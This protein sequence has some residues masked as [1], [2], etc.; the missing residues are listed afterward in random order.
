MKRKVGAV[1]GLGRGISLVEEMPD[2]KNGE[3]E[4]EV[5]A[6]LISPGSELGSC[7]S[8]RKNP[9]HSISPRPIGYANA[10]IVTKIGSNVNDFEIGQRVACMGAGYALHADRVNVP[11]NLSVV[12]PDKVTFEEAASTHLAATALHALR[13]TEPLFGEFG[14]IMGLGLV[15]QLCLQFGRLSGC[16][17]AG[18]DK[19]TLRTEKAIQGGAETVVKVGSEDPIESISDWT[20]GYGLDFGMIAF[21]GD[22]NDAFETTYRSMK[23]TPDGH[24]MGRITIVGGA[25]INHGF[26]AGLG[27]VDIRSAARTGPGYHDENYE[28]GNNYPKVFVEWDTKRNM[29]ECLNSIQSGSLRVSHLY[30]HSFAL[31][32]FDQA[33]DVLVEKPSEALGVIVNP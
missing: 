2:L 22:A 5:A 32:N 16:H 15:G 4:V 11:Q 1:D 31:D 3:I 20:K 17:I 6:S 7:G 25:E 19:Y 10:G 29:S 30:T 21:G 13:R 8:R 14:L 33:V 26:G 27:N 24:H 18:M 23:K 9:N 12:I 28:Q